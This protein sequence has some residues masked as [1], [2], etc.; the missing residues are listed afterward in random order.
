MHC[1]YLPL[2]TTSSVPS[3][4]PSVL[5]LLSLSVPSASPTVSTQTTHTDTHTHT[6]TYV[7]CSGTVTPT[8]AAGDYH[9]P[10]SEQDTAASME[11]VENIRESVHSR[12]PL[13][14]EEH[15]KFTCC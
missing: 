15:T 1:T 14:E 9:S 5:P 6:C 11:G 4:T 13:A 12:R 7:Q 8:Q 3:F 2:K 10:D